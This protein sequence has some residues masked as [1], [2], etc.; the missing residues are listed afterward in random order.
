[1]IGA[2]D[3]VG[4]WLG[5]AH[6][7]A[8]NLYAVVAAFS[9]YFCMYAFRKPFAVAEYQ[10]LTF[11]PLDLKDALIISQVL[12]YT[13]SKY[14]GVKFCS[15]I[16]P[17][18]RALALVLLIAW[19]ETALLALGLLPPRFGVVA[20]FLNGLPLG[21]VWGLVFGFLEG[22][23]TTDLLGAGLSCSYIVASGAVKSV[24]Q[25]WLTA[26]VPERWMPFVTGLTF[27]VPFLVSVWLL[28]R[29][30]PPGT[31]D[32]IERM[33]RT[34]MYSKQRWSFLGRY[35]WGLLPLL[36]LYFF[37]TAHRDF[38]D[39]Y[40][41]EMWGEFGL[42]DSAAVYAAPEVIIA[43]CVLGG[44]AMLSLVRNNRRAA[45][46][47]GL[48]TVAF[49]AGALGPA[50][51]MTLVGLGMY[52]AYVP[53]GSILFDRL[54]ALL[55]VE[56]T[57]VFTIYLADAIGYTGSVGIVLYKHF[58]QAGISKLDFFVGFNYFTS[59][60]CLVCFVFSWLYFDRTGRRSSGAS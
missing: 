48:S 24:G 2:R 53:F 3:R 60:L 20:I 26:G 51:W 47:I 21:A 10:G 15:E 13:L 43:L 32:E 16:A 54:I 28:D 45:A 31:E 8:F 33:K 40:A 42:G 52:L 14:F 29:I 37:L 6:P 19:A 39:N 56:A 17:H 44:L 27:L 4:L 1:M 46:M 25:L 57:S 9:A 11:G 35:L 18:R 34:R 30:P 59:A 55:G 41:K 12:G 49:E 5:K 7:V 38:R 23:R 58:G 22:R 36:L 50:A